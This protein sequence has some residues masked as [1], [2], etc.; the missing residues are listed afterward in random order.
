MKGRWSGE[1]RIEPIIITVLV[2][3]SQW[4]GQALAEFTRDM[5]CQALADIQVRFPPHIQAAMF[6]TNPEVWYTIGVISSVALVVGVVC[7][8]RNE[9]RYIFQMAH[10][11]GW[12]LVSIAICWVMMSVI[13]QVM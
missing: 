10:T 8:R 12:T 7:V 5:L 6:L 13:K 2:L 3:L 9:V 4:A 1:M 11:V